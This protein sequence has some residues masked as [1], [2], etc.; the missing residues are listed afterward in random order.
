MIARTIASLFLAAVL[1]TTGALAATAEMPST[2]AHSVSTVSVISSP[3][4][5]SEV[6]AVKAPVKAKK[7]GMSRV[8]KNRLIRSWGGIA[9]CRNEDASNQPLPCYWNAKVRGNGKGDSFIA[10]PSKGDDP[11]FVIIKRG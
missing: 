2:P 5:P 9:P 7:A 10:M 4:T 1:G 8:T 11:R 6:T 3:M